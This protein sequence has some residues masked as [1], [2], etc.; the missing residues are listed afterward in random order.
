[1]LLDAAEKLISVQFVF[2]GSGPAQQTDMQYDDVAASGL[3]AIENIAQVVE[4]EVTAYGHEDVASA[5]AD[6]FRR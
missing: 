2:A 4:I 5:R 3:D 1:M 6:S